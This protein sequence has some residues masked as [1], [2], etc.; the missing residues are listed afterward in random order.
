VGAVPTYI[1]RKE[2]GVMAGIAAAVGRAPDFEGYRTGEDIYIQYDDPL[3]VTEEAAL[4][5]YMVSV[6]YGFVR[7]EVGQ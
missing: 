5:A 4:T 6:G 3:T 1:Y 7:V 2:N